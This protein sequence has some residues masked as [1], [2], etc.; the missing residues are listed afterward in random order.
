MEAALGNRAAR[1]T[2]SPGEVMLGYFT[3][4]YFPVRPAFFH[5][6]SNPFI[7]WR[8]R[9]EVDLIFQ[10]QSQTWAV[11]WEVQVQQMLGP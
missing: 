11:V 1:E 8:E 3:F 6:L 9:Q 5:K 4:F 10:Q 2:E 7:L